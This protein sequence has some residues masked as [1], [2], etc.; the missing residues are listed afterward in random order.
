L[1]IGK[2]TREKVGIHGG[3]NSLNT[4]EPNILLK[5]SVNLGFDVIIC[6]NPHENFSITQDLIELNDHP[7]QAIHRGFHAC[8]GGP[9]LTL[10]AF[11]T[12]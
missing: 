10:Y 1:G 5:V 7:L 4:L 6:T 9:Y 12:G 11:D 2:N 8:K 3:L